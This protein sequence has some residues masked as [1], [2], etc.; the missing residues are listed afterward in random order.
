ME[1]TIKNIRA[2]GP[3]RADAS[4]WKHNP[5]RFDIYVGDD[6]IWSGLPFKTG[7]GWT[8][9][10]TEADILDSLAMDIASLGDGYEDNYED[11]ID[12]AE[13]MDMLGDAK[14]ARAAKAAYEQTVTLRTLILEAGAELPVPQDA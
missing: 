8:E 9:E 10:P 12:Y 14:S 3:Q 2:D 4:G 1:A 6:L 13:E 5:Y 11:W 7:T